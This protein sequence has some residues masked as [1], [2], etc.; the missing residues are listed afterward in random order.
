MG[1]V[2]QAISMRE[3]AQQHAI[4]AEHQGALRAAPAGHMPGQPPSQARDDGTPAIEG[5]YKREEPRHCTHSILSKA[6]P[7]TC[8]AGALHAP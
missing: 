4:R 3:H 2:A 5:S 7:Q 8:V 1:D 6:H